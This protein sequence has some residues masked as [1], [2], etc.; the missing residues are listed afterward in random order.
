MLSNRGGPDDPL[1]EEDLATKYADNVAGL[2][3]ADTAR[4]VYDTLADV[5]AAPSVAGLLAPL[6]VIPRTGERL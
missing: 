1:S 6:T 5:A 2:V 3:T 4:W